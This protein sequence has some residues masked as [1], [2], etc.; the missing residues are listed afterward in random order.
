MSTSLNAPNVADNQVYSGI[1]PVN[2]QTPQPTGKNLPKRKLRIRGAGPIGYVMEEAR[3]LANL[4]G[5]GAGGN[6]GGATGA[7]GG[8]ATKALA[9]T[10]KLTV[11]NSGQTGPASFTVQMNPVG[12][13]AFVCRAAQHAS[14]GMIMMVNVLPQGS[15]Q[16]RQS[17]D[18]QLNQAFQS[19][20]QQGSQTKTQVPTA[21]PGTGGALDAVAQSVVRSQTS[22]N[23]NAPTGAQ[24]GVTGGTN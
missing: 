8:G 10:G 22:R 21:N 24:Q 6:A 3:G 12:M 7:A 15:N 9:A 19:Y 18:Q 13:Q 11:Q 1:V 4:L 20:L 14:N 2:N 5:G 16:K 17:S 23:N